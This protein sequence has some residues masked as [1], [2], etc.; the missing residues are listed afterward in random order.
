MQL[1]IWFLV[2]PVDMTYSFNVCGPLNPLPYLQGLEQLMLSNL[3]PI[4]VLHVVKYTQ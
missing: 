4:L 3:Q 1:V 2:A